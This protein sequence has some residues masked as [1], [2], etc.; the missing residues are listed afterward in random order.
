MNK[1]LI[2]IYPTPID[3]GIY[4]ILSQNSTFS[5]IFAK[6]GIT[7]AEQFHALDLE[8]IYNRSGMKLV[9]DFMQMIYSKA[10]PNTNSLIAV[11]QMKFAKKWNE[12]VSTLDYDYNPLEPYQMTVEDNLSEQIDR[13]RQTSGEHSQNINSTD[14]NETTRNDNDST[15]GFNSDSSVPTDDTNSNGTYSGESAT[16]Q[17]GTNSS[18]ESGKEERSSGR[19]INRSGNIGNHTIPELI[20]EQRALLQYQILEVF[21]SDLDSVICRSRYI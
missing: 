6:L 13:S 15:Y 2:E 10:I 21:S 12:L 20:D 18:D 1:A 19:T 5:E 3:N 9:T 14:N 8:Y 16:E 17:S 11:I 4:Y 7:M